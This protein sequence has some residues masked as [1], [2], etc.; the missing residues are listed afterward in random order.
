[1]QNGFG[2]QRKTCPKRSEISIKTPVPEPT[3]EP[4]VPEADG[5]SDSDATVDYRSE[6][7][8]A[9]VAGDDDVLIRLPKNF[10]VPSFVPLDGDGFGSC[11]G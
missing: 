5:D 8:L 1:M 6:S 10:A 7:L 2:H 9:L 11:R 3:P 4:P